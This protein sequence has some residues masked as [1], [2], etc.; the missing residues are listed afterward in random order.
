[1]YNKR[2]RNQRRKGLNGFVLR[3]SANLEFVGYSSR[4]LH[5]ADVK[6]VSGKVVCDH[7]LV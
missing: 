2:E 1:M 7:K 3:P 4:N 6:V 5:R